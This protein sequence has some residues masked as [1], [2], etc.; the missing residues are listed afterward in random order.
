[1]SEGEMV[2]TTLID[3][4]ERAK[5]SPETFSIPS[6]DERWGLRVGDFAKIGLSSENGGERF[7]VKISNVRDS[8]SEECIYTGLVN[9]DLIVFAIPFGSPVEFDPCHV[10]SIIR[11][12]RTLH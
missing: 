6:E 2:E 3:G 11:D 1:M 8:E 4:E 5:S 10:L 9:N 7:W 12:G